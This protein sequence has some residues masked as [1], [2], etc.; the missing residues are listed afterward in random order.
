[1]KYSAGDIFID[2]FGKTIIIVEII[3]PFSSESWREGQYPHYSIRI[4]GRMSNLRW[5]DKDFD[6][7]KNISCPVLKELNS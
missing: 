7:Y 6:G 4:E 1:M 3:M 2:R 5:Y